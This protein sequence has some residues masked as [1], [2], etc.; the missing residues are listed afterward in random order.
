[1]TTAA[2][3]RR[4]LGPLRGMRP[5]W[6]IAW[7]S[8]RRVCTVPSRVHAALS[9][10]G[11]AR[12]GRSRFRCCVLSRAPRRVA[13]QI[14]GD[15]RDSSGLLTTS[16]GAGFPRVLVEVQPRIH[17]SGLA[18]ASDGTALVNVAH[19][20]TTRDPHALIE[21]AIAEGGELFVGVQ[22]SAREARHILRL[23]DD[24]AAEAAGVI[25]GRRHRRRR[26]KDRNSAR[27]GS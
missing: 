14:R 15:V 7:P 19:W 17:G 5:L 24:R 23:I 11:S 6:S 27:S 22:V 4:V 8:Q 12:A 18:F 9:R 10:T 21:H 1:M 3:D 26:A 20:A 25:G 13:P 2:H 16:E